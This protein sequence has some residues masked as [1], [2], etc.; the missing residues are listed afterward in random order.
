MFDSLSALRGLEAAGI[1]S[2]HAEAIVAAI[3]HAGEEV[4]TKSD[5]AAGVAALEARIERATTR[6]LLAVIAVGG[7]VIAAVKLL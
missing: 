3:G 2:R 5:L 7:T 4:V 6:T 1:D